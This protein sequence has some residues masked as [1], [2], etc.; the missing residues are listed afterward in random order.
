M[1]RESLDINIYKLGGGRKRDVGLHRVA[2][3]MRWDR[4]LGQ[5][6]DRSE[7]HAQKGDFS[8]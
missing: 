3:E 6:V 2:G 4:K 1:R 8:L 5:V 7:G